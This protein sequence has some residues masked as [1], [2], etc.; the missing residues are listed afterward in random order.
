MVTKH[1]KIINYIKTIPVGNKLSVRN[2]AKE[3]LSLIHI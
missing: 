3:M 1:E 2:I